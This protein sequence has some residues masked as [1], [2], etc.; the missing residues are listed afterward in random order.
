[1]PEPRPQPDDLITLA[2]AARLTGISLGGLQVQRRRG[3][4]AAHK[5]GRDWVLRRGELHR[6][7]LERQRARPTPLSPDYV[8]PSSLAPLPDARRLAKLAAR[9]ADDPH[10][11]ASALARW[12]ADE[13]LSDPAIAMALGIHLDDLI[14]LRLCRRPDPAQARFGADLATIAAHYGAHAAI[15]DRV[16]RAYAPPEAAPP[17]AP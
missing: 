1:M 15:L 10:F 17:D 5:L 8:A 12:Q 11:L 6:Y 16:L 13:Q 4:L 7:L 14:A 3:Q 2:D 9:V